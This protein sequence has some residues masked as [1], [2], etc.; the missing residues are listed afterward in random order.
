M[1]L[2]TLAG[3]LAFGSLTF[4]AFWIGIVIATLVLVGLTDNEHY[5]WATVVLVGFF[6]LVGWMGIFNLYT[7]TYTNPWGVLFYFLGYLGIGC[8][9]GAAKWWQFCKKMRDIY[10][11]AKADFLKANG[12]T[13]LNATLRV[14]W[15][16]K[17][18]NR[19]RYD[20]HYVLCA[21]APVASQNKEKIMNWM[22]LWPFSM[23]GTF[24][25]DFLRNIWTKLYNWMGGIYD[26]ISLAV[27]KGT[28]NDL[29]SE[30]DL[31]EA[32]AKG[33]R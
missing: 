14:E 6:V 23:L 8:V 20:R 17:L 7:Y 25:S 11:T 4:W 10:E 18:Q 19:S 1:E 3:A 16:K 12:A 31:A 29:A 26:S 9:W 32:A 13:E 24:L 28:E 33:K 21:E 30:E 2:L 22:Y 27:W 5:G 15:T